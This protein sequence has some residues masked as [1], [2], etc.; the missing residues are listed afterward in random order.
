[1]ARRTPAEQISDIIHIF[2]EYPYEMFTKS[3]IQKI[4]NIH[5]R[6]IN[7][8]LLILMDLGFIERVKQRYKLHKERHALRIDNIRYTEC[9]MTGEKETCLQVYDMIT[10]KTHTVS[11]KKF[12][13]WWY[14][15]CYDER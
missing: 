8:L 2:K 15:H 9:E 4:T 14:A 1:M 7:A 5:I 11:M 12:R 6:H 13:Q 10:K 3:E